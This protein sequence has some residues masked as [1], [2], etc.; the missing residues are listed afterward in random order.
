MLASLTRE[1]AIQL[2]DRLGANAIRALPFL[3]EVWA[4]PDHQ[5]AQEGDWSTWLLMGGRG[6]G[7]TRAGAEWVRA[8]VE[9]P[10]P[11]APGK[12]CHIA[13]LGETYDQALKVMVE[14]P[15]GILACSPPDRRPKWEATRRRLVWANGAMATVYSAHDPEALRGP[16][17]A[18][19]W[20]DELGKW[21][22]GQDTWDML[23]FALRL[24]DQPRIC[25]TT[26]PRR[27]AVLEDLMNAP[28]TVM[29]QAPTQANAHNLAPGFMDYID[30]QFSGTALGRQEL[31][32][33]LVADLP[34]ALWTREALEAARA[35]KDETVPD[36]DWIVVA[37]DPPA[38]S[39]D[40]SDACG[41]VVAGVV[42]QGGPKDWQATVLEDAT[43]QAATPLGWAEAAV[44]AAHRWSA[45][46]II[47]EINQGGAMVEAMVR[48]VDPM[49]AYRGVHASRGKSARAEPVAALYEQ[50]RV[51]H[52]GGFAELEDQLC[53][54]TRT[55]YARPGSP[56]RADALVWAL[57]ELMIVPA[58]THLRPG[59][60]VL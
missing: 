27:V 19:A 20:A 44:A 7:K 41:I 28:G 39:S 15:S 51:F 12:C 16:Q 37:V 13:L 25:V 43:I 6:A 54:L 49:I 42:T 11:D 31:N 14:G 29:T 48:Q 52:R 59:L 21:K 58:K 9:G 34:G 5:L 56:D 17:F 38:G 35:S 33:E 53:A 22:K 32:G 55:G 26:T 18:C 1:E 50:G 57:T 46:R 45:E 3:F 36:F 2:V 24:G 40:S 23:A 30:A 4:L 10:T 60:R 47:A 8:Q